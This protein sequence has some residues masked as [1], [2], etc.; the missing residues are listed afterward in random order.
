MQSNETLDG[1]LTENELNANVV[2]WRR[3]SCPAACSDEGSL[4]EDVPAKAVLDFVWCNHL[5]KVALE[6]KLE[7]PEA[8]F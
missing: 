1:N 8:G 4:K 7:I 5:I 3:K 2:R 6:R